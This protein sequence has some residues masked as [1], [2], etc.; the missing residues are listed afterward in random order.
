MEIIMLGY[1]GGRQFIQVNLLCSGIRILLV[2]T[3]SLVQCVN[4]IRIETILFF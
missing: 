2:Q 3:L 1:N 4:E